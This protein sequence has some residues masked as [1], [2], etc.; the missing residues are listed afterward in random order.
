MPD[1]CKENIGHNTRTWISYGTSI[2]KMLGRQARDPTGQG[3]RW[4]DFK[5]CSVTCSCKYTS[6]R[7]SATPESFQDRRGKEP[8]C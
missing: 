8:S 5:E 2:E 4:I 7:R 3:P 6:T 1:K